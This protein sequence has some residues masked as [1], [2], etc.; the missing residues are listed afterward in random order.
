MG[1]VE[2]HLPIPRWRG[3]RVVAADGSAVRLTMMKEN[4]RSIV[5]GMAFGLYLPGIELFLSFRLHEPLSDERQMFFEAIDCLRTDD[6]LLMDRGFPCRWLVSALTARRIPFVI[7][8]DL[9]QGFK[10]VREFLKSGRSEQVVVLRAPN[11]R[12]AQ[13]YECPATPTTVRLVRVVTPNGRVH[14]VMTS[15]L[16]PVTF[17]AA[18]FADLYHGR[19]RIEEAFKRIKHQRNLEY[20][21]GWSWHAARQDFCA[22]TVL[23]KH[24]ALAAY[25]A[26]AA[27]LDPSSR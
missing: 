21:S 8:C 7:R 12:D 4:I 18:A 10:V 6:V 27:F 15:L 25:A 9:S 20:T 17:P 13:D 2:E 24:K 3:L 5:T 1:L 23:D 19:W 11:A 26:T 14:V 16:D 22:K